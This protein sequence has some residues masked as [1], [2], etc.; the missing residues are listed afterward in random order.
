MI[1]QFCKFSP[2]HHP[3][4]R[5]DMSAAEAIELGRRSIYHATFRDAVSGGTVSVYHVTEVCALWGGGGCPGDPSIPF[6]IMIP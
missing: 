1:H 6:C 2:P 5:F 4:H 3:S